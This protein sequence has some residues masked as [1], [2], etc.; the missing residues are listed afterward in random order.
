M[1]QKRQ[2]SSSSPEVVA[3]KYGIRQG[4]QMRFIA[5]RRLEKSGHREANTFPVG[6]IVLKTRSRHNEGHPNVNKGGVV[7]SHFRRTA[8]WG[9]VVLSRRAASDRR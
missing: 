3:R 9:F 5:P 1:A 4:A 6:E 7:S 8:V 2:P